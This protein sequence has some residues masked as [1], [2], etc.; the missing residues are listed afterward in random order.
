[1][2]LTIQSC[3]IELYY[4]WW[5]Y[6]KWHFDASNRYVFN[7]Y[8]LQLITNMHSFYIEYALPFGGVG[9]S[10]MGA[11]HGEKSFQCFSHE[12]A[13]LVKKQRLEW[14]IQSRYPPVT[15]TKLALLRAVLV[16]NPIQFWFIVFKKPVKWVTLIIIILGIFVKRRLS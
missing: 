12:R 2:V 15:K 5:C 14:L 13:I 8:M 6:C 7:M 9:A 1:M 16:T 10:G 3:S 11:Y 4:F